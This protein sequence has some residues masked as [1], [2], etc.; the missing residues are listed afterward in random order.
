[1]MCNLCVYCNK[2]RKIFYCIHSGEFMDRHAV[3]TNR[4]CD[5][6]EQSQDKVID[7]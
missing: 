4:E 5:D 7:I 3:I 6:F 1:M 2:Y